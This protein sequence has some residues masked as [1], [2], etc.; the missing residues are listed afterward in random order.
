MKELYLDA[1]MDVVKFSV[2]DVIATS[3]DPAAPEET[4][5]EWQGMGGPNEGA[6]G[7]SFLE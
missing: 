4:T 1:E 3:G 5:T 2:E 7:D 6:P